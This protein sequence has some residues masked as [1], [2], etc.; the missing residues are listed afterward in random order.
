MIDEISE[1]IHKLEEVSIDLRIGA[2]IIPN[3]LKT[4]I[5][6]NAKTCAVVL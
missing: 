6:I 3:V 2:A 5:K 4:K 1:E